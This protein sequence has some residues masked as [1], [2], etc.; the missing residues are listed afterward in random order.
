[1]THDKAASDFRIRDY[2]PVDAV[3]LAKLFYDCVHRVNSRDYSAEQLEAWAPKEANLD[4]W[5]TR[6]NNRIAIV[7]ES[8]AKFAGFADMTPTGHLDRLFVSADHQRLGVGRMLVDELKLRA[9][10]LGIAEMS[11]DA[12]ITA[13]PFFADQ[14]FMV[15]CEQMVSCRGQS[16][17]NYK[18]RYQ[19]EI[20]T[21]S[22]S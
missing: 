19:I 16:L 6:F 17:T 13:R 18:M 22:S 20:K 4:A 12:S 9:S 2:R 15:V 7:P 11:T 14:G 1:M 21:D 8:D 10:E 3:P 5:R